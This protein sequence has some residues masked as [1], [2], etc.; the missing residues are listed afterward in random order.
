MDRAIENIEV[1]V[2]RS[3]PEA[4]E[5]EVEVKKRGRQA[6]KPTPR[7]PEAGRRVNPDAAKDSPEANERRAHLDALKAEVSKRHKALAEA[8]MELAKAMRQ[9]AGAGP[10]PGPFA[11][12]ERFEFRFG[13]PGQGPFEQEKMIKMIPRPEQDRRIGELEEKLEKLQDEVKSLKKDAPSR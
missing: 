3:S 11:H 5:N 4:D 10:I 12:N 13:K 2:K 9:L 6:E 7:K 8:Q 1:I